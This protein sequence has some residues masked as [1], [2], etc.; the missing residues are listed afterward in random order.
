MP[1][2][3]YLDLLDANVESSLFHVASSVFAERWSFQVEEKWQISRRGLLF[4][5]LEQ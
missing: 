4:S 5:L 1:F 2:M 3:V